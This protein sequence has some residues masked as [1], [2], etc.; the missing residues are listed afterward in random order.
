MRVRHLRSMAALAVFSLSAAIAT[1]K[2]QLQQVGVMPV[3]MHGLRPHVAAKI[4][5]VPASFLLDTGAFYSVVWR[6]AAARYRLPISHILG[7]AFFV[8]GVGGSERAD[9]ATAKSFEFLGIPMS[10]VQFVVLNPDLEGD[11]TGIIGQNL[12]MISDVEYDLADGV[13]RFLKPDDCKGQPLAYWAVS[14]PY[15]FVTLQ[16]LRSTGFHLGAT[17]LVNGH[18]MTAWFDTGSSRSY[19]SLDAAA[20]AGITTTSPGVT[21]LGTGEG[22]GVRAVRTWVAPVD[23]FQLGGEKV[24]H[25]HLLMADLDPERTGRLSGAPPDVLLGEDFFLSHRIYVAYSQE[26]LYFTYNGGPLFNLNL[27]QVVS[28]QEKPPPT[29]DGG[30]HATAGTGAGTDASTPTD[31]GGFRRRGMAYAS[32]HEFDRALADLTRACELAPGDPENHYDRGMVYDDT[33]QFKTALQDFDAAI[34]LQPENTDARLERVRLLSAHPDADP[35]VTTTDLKADLDAVSHAAAP[36]A[37]VRL[38]LGDLYG[39]IGDYSAALGQIDQ[40]LDQHPLKGDQAAGLNNR[41]WLRATANRDLRE[42][43]DDCNRALELTPRTW[44]TTGS[45]ITKAVVTT[46]RLGGPRQPGT[47]RA[48]AR[49]A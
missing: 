25:A 26:K 12:L 36:D 16:G 5:G 32:M 13:V 4:D 18:R 48:A 46:D 23:S 42:A 11:I 35:A 17:V 30:S 31:A 19:L 1:A 14:T 10:N 45:R 29:L 34:K 24:Q 9:V 41:C 7:G 44:E 22:I 39:K 43:L 15:S 33:G 27:P 6:D 38:T 47:R 3:E 40:W 28:G 8:S 37:N 2:C 21:F 20:R 49:Q